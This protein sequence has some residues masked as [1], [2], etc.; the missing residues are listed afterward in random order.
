MVRVLIADNDFPSALDVVRFVCALGHEVVGIFCSLDG[1]IRERRPSVAFIGL[2]PPAIEEG[3]NA[4]KEMLTAGAA[5]VIMIDPQDRL[6]Q[7]SVKRLGSCAVLCKPITLHGVEQ[8]LRGC[9]R[10]AAIA[11]GTGTPANL[12]VSPD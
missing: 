9:E 11:E 7:S 4:A 2:T 8:A 3:I 10:L 1:E 6:V 12:G 5:V